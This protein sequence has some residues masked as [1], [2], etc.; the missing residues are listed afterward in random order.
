MSYENLDDGFCNH[1]FSSKSQLLLLSAKAILAFILWVMLKAPR[2]HDKS[3]IHGIE[4]RNDQKCYQ[5]NPEICQISLYR[6]AFINTGMSVTRPVIF[7]AI[8]RNTSGDDHLFPANN[9]V[10]G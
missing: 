7:V 4:Y 1:I 6:I 10:L 9:V 8:L 3:N 2:H 5:K